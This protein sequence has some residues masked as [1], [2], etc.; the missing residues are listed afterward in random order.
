[1]KRYIKEL[2]GIW[3]YPP[4]NLDLLEPDSGIM[5]VFTEEVLKNQEPI[6]QMIYSIRES[7]DDL[8]E[9]QIHEYYKVVNY[10]DGKNTRKKT[11]IDLLKFFQTIR[12][13]VILLDTKKIPPFWFRRHLEELFLLID[14]N[15][16][17]PLIMNL[18]EVFKHTNP[19]GI[20]KVE[21][22]TIGAE[23]R[24]MIKGYHTKRYP[25]QDLV[26]RAAW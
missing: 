11:P 10:L 26:L 1:M 15:E 14:N 13:D 21:M 6:T 18:H 8:E 7:I 2:I 3:S 9:W 22:S 20:I 23:A 19:L 16:S 5:L 4:T 25:H 24:R 12:A 17:I